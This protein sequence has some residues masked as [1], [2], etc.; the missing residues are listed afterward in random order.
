MKIGA[1]GGWV[2]MDLHHLIIH[3]KD[4]ALV[5]AVILYRL[6]QGLIGEARPEV[7]LDFDDGG[8]HALLRERSRQFD[9]N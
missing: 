8:V 4:H 7:R 9:S 2:R 6:C 5:R 3:D 1:W